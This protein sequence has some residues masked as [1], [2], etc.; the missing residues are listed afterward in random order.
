MRDYLMYK[1]YKNWMLVRDKNI[2]LE[3]VFRGIEHVLFDFDGTLS[4][5]RRGWEEIMF[6]VMIEAICGNQNFSPEIESEVRNYIDSS[7]GILTIEQMEWLSQ[8]VRRYELVEK[9]LSA[10]EYKKIYL[11]RLMKIVD[12]RISLID[13]Q[14]LAPKSMMVVGA[15]KI[16]RYL[17]KSGRDLYLA[18]GTDHA[19]VLHEAQVLKL[20]KYFGEHI[21]GALD[22]SD[23]NNKNLII[24]RIL[25]E[26]K[27]EGEHLLV[28]GDGPVE[29]REAKKRGA[30]SLGIASDEE[31]RFGW[32]YQKIDRL[33]KAN[34]D[35]IIP[36]FSHTDELIS[37][38][39]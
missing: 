9:V 19:D 20:K 14:N 21:Y 36:D 4:V 37:L 32:N 1:D 5:L 3:T 17:S 11:S 31:N 26:N 12:E 13:Q 27:L 28:V 25:D 6:P 38:F 2:N 24:Q 10:A 16:V 34:A 7:T 22:K 30:L 18:S 23:K 33:I 29:I 35:L 39:D 8:A 15:K